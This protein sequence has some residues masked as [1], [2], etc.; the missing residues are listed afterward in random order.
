[1]AHRISGY[2]NP[3]KI[4]SLLDAA[5]ALYEAGVWKLPENEVSAEDQDTLWAN[6]RDALMLR[7]GHSTDLFC[8]PDTD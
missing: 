3:D 7:P 4:I 5:L 1:M 8:L 2:S 6:L